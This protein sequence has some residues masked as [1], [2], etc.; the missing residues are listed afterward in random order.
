MFQGKGTRKTKIV[1]KKEN[2]MGEIT[3]SYIKTY[4]VIVIKFAWY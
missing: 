4:I 2:K 1:L 3:L